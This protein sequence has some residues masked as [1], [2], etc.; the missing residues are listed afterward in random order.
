MARKSKAAQPSPAPIETLYGT[1]WFNLLSLRLEGRAWDDVEQPFHRLPARAKAVVREPVWTLGKRGT[2]LRARF[3]T[4]SPSVDVRWKNVVD[5]HYDHMPATGTAG[6]DLYVRDGERW[7]FAGIGRQTR[8]GY[9]FSALVHSLP[10]GPKEFMLHLPLY[11]EVEYAHIGV[12]AGRSMAPAP[13]WPASVKPMLFYGT[14]ITHGG[15]ASR[16]GMAYPAIV[17]RLLQR[18]FWNISFDGNAFMDLDLARLFAEL[19]PSVYVI[20]A[21]A[22]M[23]PDMVR[24]RAVEFVTILR[25]ARPRTPIVLM[26]RPLGHTGPLFEAFQGKELAAALRESYEKLLAGGIKGLTYV[27]GSG[28]LGDDDE[29]TVDACHPTDLGFMHMAQ[30]MA[31]ILRPLV[32]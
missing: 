13:A 28:L 25:R 16:P 8:S 20:D 4:D 12:P 15:C 26:E 22:N 27:P 29:G 2:G 1:A 11:S 5:M 17:S 7:R 19:D 10:V 3:V 6:V 9:N 32:C 24:Q 23:T 30:A 21:V 14:S 18:P 31:P